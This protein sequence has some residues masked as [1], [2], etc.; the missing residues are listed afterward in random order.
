LISA[1]DTNVLLDILVPEAPQLAWA[2]SALNEAASDGQLIISEPTYAELAPFFPAAGDL[3]AFLKA[4]AIELLPSSSGA[5][6]EGG[7]AWRRYASRRGAPGCP[8]CGVPQRA[9]CREC[10][11]ELF[12]RQHVIAGF[13]IGS[14]AATHADRLLTRDRGFFSMYFPD[15]RLVSP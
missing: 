8:R 6:Y 3:A 13:M 12:P 11:T 7:R 1:V 5:L 2:R 14:H 15:L 4:T 9:P 10:G